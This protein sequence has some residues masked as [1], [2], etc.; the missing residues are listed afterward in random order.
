MSVGGYIYLWD[1]RSGELVTKLQATP[2]CSTI[3]SVSFSSDAKFFVTAG[4]K[5][6]KFWIIGS[7]RKTQLNAG[8][9]RT[10]SLAIHEKPVN[11]SIHKGSS[12]TSIT[13][14]W[15]CSTYDNCKQPDD[16]FPIYTLTDSG[17]IPFRVSLRLKFIVLKILRHSCFLDWHDLLAICSISFLYVY[18]HFAPYSFS[19]LLLFTGILYLINSGM[20]VEKS[21]TLKVCPAFYHCRKISEH[22]KSIF[23]KRK[24]WWMKC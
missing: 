21:V 1:W 7:S 4:K 3:S 6:L 12:F 9:S 11:L 13:S 5:H 2:S 10:T 24:S 22:A 17:L 16:C 19:F 14:V 20:S 23:L 15:G 8:M 18:W